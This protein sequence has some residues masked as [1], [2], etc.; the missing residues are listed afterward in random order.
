MGKILTK[1]EVVDVTLHD[2]NVREK[3]MSCLLMKRIRTS[4]TIH[5]IS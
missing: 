1:Y 3:N 5:A 4:Q 2:E